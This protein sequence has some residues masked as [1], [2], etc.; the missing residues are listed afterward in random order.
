[1]KGIYVLILYLMRDKCLRIGALGKLKFQNGFYAYIGS[2]QNSLEKRIERHL[3]KRKKLRWHIDYLLEQGEIK[4][5][6]IKKNASR[7]E[8][9]SIAEIFSTMFT[10]VRK[11]GASD[12]RCEAHL[13]YLGDKYHAFITKLKKHKLRNYSSITSTS[14]S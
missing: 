10:P 7:R 2:A 8:E 4:E 13:F 14:N 3:S 12:C 1:M 6:W 5:V 11:F 9:C